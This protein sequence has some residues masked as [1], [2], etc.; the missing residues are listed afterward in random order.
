[1][2]LLRKYKN[3]TPDE[4]SQYSKILAIDG[5]TYSSATINNTTKINASWYNNA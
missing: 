2:D 4:V 3:Y 5:R 1:M